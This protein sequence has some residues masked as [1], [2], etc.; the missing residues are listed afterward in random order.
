MVIGMSTQDRLTAV[1]LRD[2][3]EK[4]HAA[5]RQE[6]IRLGLPLSKYLARLVA[7]RSARLLNHQEH[8][9]MDRTP[10]EGLGPEASDDLP[11]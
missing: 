8:T 5:L 7:E 1:D 10:S 11:V 2:L 6:A 4:E 9:P 3:S